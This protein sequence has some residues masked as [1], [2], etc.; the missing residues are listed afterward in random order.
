MSEMRGSWPGGP[1]RKS[2][3]SEVGERRAPGAA[4]LERAEDIEARVTAAHQGAQRSRRRKRV[5]AGLAVAVA[6]A[7]GIGLYLGYRAHL[8][9][10]A[11]TAG[12]NAAGQQPANFDPSLQTNRVLDELWKMEIKQRQPGP[13]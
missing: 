3:G 8:N 12:R 7:G 13:P 4:H 2:T 9:A 10:E 1:S 5:L 11:I 6:V